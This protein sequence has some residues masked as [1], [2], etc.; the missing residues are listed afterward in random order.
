VVPARS[1]P[2]MASGAWRP[3]ACRLNTHMTSKQSL[4]P[5]CP[6]SLNIERCPYVG[7]FVQHDAVLAPSTPRVVLT[8]LSDLC[9]TFTDSLLRKGTMCEH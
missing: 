5:G 8:S 6:A 3:H 1:A 7:Y 4:T 9:L 2:E